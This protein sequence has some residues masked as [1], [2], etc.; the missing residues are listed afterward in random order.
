MQV[1][2]GNQ[3]GDISK[4]IESYRAKFGLDQPLWRQYLS[5]WG[6]LVH[7][8]LGYSLARFPSRVTDEIA[9]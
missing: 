1:L 2:S 6:D 8:D 4:I 7:G 3:I 5:Y 9:P